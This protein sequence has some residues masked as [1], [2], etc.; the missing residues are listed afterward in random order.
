MAAGL[1]N[2]FIACMYN[3]F[4]CLIQYWRGSG[5]VLYDGDYQRKESIGGKSRAHNE[6][7]SQSSLQVSSPHRTEEDLVDFRVKCYEKKGTRLISQTLNLL[8]AASHLLL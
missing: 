1:W 3:M 5:E 6:L 4:C 7:P 2:L 8:L